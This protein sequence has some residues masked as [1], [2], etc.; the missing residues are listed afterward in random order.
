MGMYTGVR[1]KVIVKEEY[2][3]EL[4]YLISNRLNWNNSD[5]ALFRIYSMYSRANF[6]PYGSLAY[7]PDEWERST[8]RKDEFGYI[9]EAT[10]GFELNFNKDTGYW[11][12]QCSL[13]NY[14][15]T[16]HCFFKYILSNIAQEIIHLETYYEED[17]YSNSYKLEDGK[18]ILDN[19]K[20]IRYN[21]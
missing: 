8:G 13:K 14:D 21:N 20:F 5:L 16:I 15:D 3:E 18:I 12:F 10:D 4:D 2:R 7:M 1:C 19:S 17:E 11:S 9:L 6:I